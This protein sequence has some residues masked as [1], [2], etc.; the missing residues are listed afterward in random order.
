MAQTASNLSGTGYGVFE[1]KLERDL[2]FRKVDANNG[3]SAALSGNTIMISANTG[4]GPDQIIKLDG[5]SRYPAADGRNITSLNPANFLS[6]GALPM[7]A[8]NLPHNH[9]FIGSINSQPLAT[10]TSNIPISA[11]GTAIGN[12]DIGSYKIATSATS[13]ASNELVPRSYVDGIIQGVRWK[14]SVRVASTGPIDLSN[15]GTVIDGVSMTLDTR[16]LVKDQSTLS[17]NG[18]YLWKSATS[19]VRAPDAETVDELRSMAVFIEEGTHADE[20]WMLITDLPITIGV[21]GLQYSGFT[22][23]ADVGIAGGLVKIGKNL[24]VLPDDETI[25]LYAGKVAVRSHAVAGMP[26][27]SSGVSGT[28]STWGQ[29]DLSS[30]V[31]TTGILPYNKG[32]TGRSTAAQHTVY[33]SVT[34][35]NRMETITVGTFS[36]VGRRDSNLESLTAANLRELTNTREQTDTANATAASMTL[37]TLSQVPLSAARV[38]I[39]YNGL[40]LTYNVDYTISGQTVTATNALNISYGGG[41]NDGLGFEVTDVIDARYEW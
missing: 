20:G 23:V 30:D 6:N 28:P 22:G 1:G 4:T 14:A 32:G 21:T 25:M 19:M 34:Q 9:V 8:I 35:G 41:G 27:V 33:G 24:A 13:W 18:L 38:S 17:Q 39:Y 15:P 2:R 7:G 3:L 11:W 26:M 12:M 16:V 10:P 5:N 36:V 37:I 29:I 40:R 31:V